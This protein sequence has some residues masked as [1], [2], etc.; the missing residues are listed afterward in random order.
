[1]KRLILILS[2]LAF[3]LT[4]CGIISHDNAKGKFA[5]ISTRDATPEKPIWYLYI[6]KNGKLKRISDQYGGPKWNK[7]GDKLYCTSKDGIWILSDEGEQI[8]FIKTPYSPI[9]IDVSDDE[10]AI[11]YSAEEQIDKQKK[12]AYLYIYNTQ[13]GEH[14]KIFATDEN[15]YIHD[16]RLSPGKQTILCTISSW[17]SKAPNVYAIDINGNK[18]LIWERAMYA[19]WFP[20]GE[21]ILLDTKCKKD[22]SPICN[23]FLGALIK[24]NLKTMNYKIVREINSSTLYT[25][26][27]RN[28]KYIYYS[29]PYDKGKYIVLSPLSNPKKEIQITKPVRKITDKGVDLGYSQD[30]FADWYQGN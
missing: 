13:T 8:K 1:M 20:D 25:K 29:K 6:L 28:T 14:K 16:V 24:V 10:Q 3:S 30:F 26:L 11:A 12:L 18:R 22:G 23:A 19:S 4:G 2:I 27:S 21:N 7:S 5:F 9:S 17:S 15:Y